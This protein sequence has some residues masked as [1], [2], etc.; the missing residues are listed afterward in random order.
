MTLF[1]TYGLGS[2]V[3]MG[4]SFSFSLSSLSSIVSVGVPGLVAAWLQLGFWGLIVITLFIGREWKE[5]TFRNQILAGQSRLSIYFSS[6]IVCLVIALA[7]LLVFETLMLVTGSLFGVPFFTARQLADTVNLGSKFA[8]S[9]TLLFV[10]YLMMACAATSWSYIIPNSWGSLGVF[11]ASCLALL[12]SVFIV[13]DIAT[14]NHTSLYLLENFLPGYQSAKLMAFDYD[15]AITSYKDMG[16]QGYVYY[17]PQ[18]TAGHATPF[19]L[20]TVFSNLFYA[21]AMTFLG[22]FSFLKR[23]LK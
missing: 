14:R 6:L 16:G 21:A 15:N 7:N 8:V 3:A 17:M 2:Y 13:D 18:T 20:T 9:I 5:R 23:D 1:D 12:F 22:C 19:I 10:I 4:L 11:Y